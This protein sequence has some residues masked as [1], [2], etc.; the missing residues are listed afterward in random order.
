M[1]ITSL[2]FLFVFL[3]LAL[4]VYYIADDTVKDYVLLA[5]SLF[6]YAI[7]SVEYLVTFVIA[8][9]ITVFIGRAIDE[10]ESHFV[11]RVLLLVGIAFNVGLL[12]Y[13]KY[14]NFVLITFG[15]IISNDYVEIEQVLL[16][17]GISFFTFKSISYLVDVYKKKIELDKNPFHDALYLSFFTQISSGPITRYDSMNRQQD[18]KFNLFSDGV[19]RFLIGFNKKIL[20]ANVLANVTKEVFATDLSAVSTMYLWLG[21][22]CYSLQL[23]FDFAGYS[24]MAI[25]ISEMFG[26]RC[27][28]N[29]NYPYMTE[30][31]SKFWRRW[32]ISLSEWFRDYVY[33]PLGGSKTKRKWQIY[34]NLFVVWVLTGIWHGAAWNFIMW[35]IGYFVVISFEKMTGMPYK[36]KTL[37]GKTIYRI[38]TLVFVNFQWVVFNSQSFTDGARRIKKML[39]YQNNNLSD[40]RTLFLLKEYM[41]FIVVAVILCFPLV[42]WIERKTVNNK[43]LNTI[44]EM[45]EFIVIIMAFVWALSFVVAGQNNPFAYANF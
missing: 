21:S 43:A 2:L 1:S 36:L 4:A 37:F 20:L 42:P 16:P 23:L 9:T 5:I 3:P 8:I 18:G 30:S 40:N 13:F 11:K 19:T 45:L 35:G 28:E 12:L 22:V 10:N 41:F 26:Y 15:R 17:L 29:F 6:F 14:A 31:V 32:H 38:F 24:D 25:G 7:G 39:I 33:F 34:F 27:M 44:F